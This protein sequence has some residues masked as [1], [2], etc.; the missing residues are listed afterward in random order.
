V[1]AKIG[2][3]SEH[4]DVYLYGKNIFDTEYD[5]E[6][7]YG[8]YYTVYSDPKRDRYSVNLSFLKTERF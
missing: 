7:Y 2:Y 3:E 4:Y 5:S 8:G 1:N 6:G